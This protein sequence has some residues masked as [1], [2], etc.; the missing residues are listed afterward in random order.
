MQGVVL[1]RLATGQKQGGPRQGNDLGVG[2]AILLQVRRQV[3]M[4]MVKAAVHHGQQFFGQLAAAVSNDL[5]EQGIPQIEQTTGEMYRVA[6][7][8]L[9]FLVDGLDGSTP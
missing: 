1:H 3:W 9:E 4:I 2:T 7:T 5:V 8:Y 6:K